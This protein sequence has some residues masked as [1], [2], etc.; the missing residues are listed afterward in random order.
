MRRRFGQNDVGVCSSESERI[1]AGN[2][3]GRSVWE[4]FEL[5]RHAQLELLEI[6]MRVR[7]RKMEAG[8]NLCVLE[9]QHRLEQ[10]G[11]ARGGFQMAKVSFYGADRARGVALSMAAESIRESMRL[12]GISHRCASSGGFD[13]AT[14]FWRT[15][16]ILASVLHQAG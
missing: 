15:P 12:D 8:R 11:D 3:L 1:D 6:D 7:C 2:A 13:K 5:G 9:R 16:G 10:P 4:W 14:T